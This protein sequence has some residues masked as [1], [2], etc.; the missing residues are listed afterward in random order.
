MIT[1]EAVPTQIRAFSEL[2][3]QNYLSS[4]SY[5]AAL[6][7]NLFLHLSTNIIIETRMKMAYTTKI[8]SV[9]VCANMTDC[10]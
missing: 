5:H 8:A 2:V 10:G 9:S 4:M 3:K 6:F 1:A 7:Y